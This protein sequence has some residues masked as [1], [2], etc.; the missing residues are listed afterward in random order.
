[1]R[2]KIIINHFNFNHEYRHQNRLTCDQLI[3]VYIGIG[4]DLIC[5]SAQISSKVAFMGNL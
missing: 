1:M 5:V 4:H 2:C 3:H